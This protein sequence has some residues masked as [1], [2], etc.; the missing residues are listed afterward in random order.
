MQHKILVVDGEEDIVQML[1]NFFGNQKLP[2]ADCTEWK[3]RAQ[4]G[5]TSAGYYLLDV[6][7]PQMDGFQVCRRIRD[8][9]ST[10]EFWI[11]S[12]FYSN[13]IFNDDKRQL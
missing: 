1:R 11:L 3:R 4:A 13:I 9:A 2:S 12:Q 5:R 10:A 8:Y 7:M 6:N